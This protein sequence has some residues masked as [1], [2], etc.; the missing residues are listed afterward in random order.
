[1]N[2]LDPLEAQLEA[3][4]EEIQQLRAELRTSQ[5]HLVR[6]LELLDRQQAQIVSQQASIARLDSNFMDLTT[7]RVWRTLRAAGEIAKKILPAGQRDDELSSGQ[8]NTYLVCDEPRATDARPRSGMV[9]VRGWCLAQR[10][11]DAVQLEAPGLPVIQVTTV[12]SAPGRKEVA[13][14]SGHDRPRRL[15]DGVRFHGPR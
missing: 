11:V 8:S 12:D 13:P 15:R 7:G 1:M 3:T 2:R 14:Q 6:V 5:L 9:A 10:G 4:R